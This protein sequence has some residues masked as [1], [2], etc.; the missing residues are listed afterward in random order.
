MSR[1]KS[2]YQ[3]STL[4]ALMAGYYYPVC[5]VGELLAHGDFGIGTFEG[6]DGE[7]IALDGVCYRAKSDGNVVP[8]S[9]EENVSFASIVSFQGEYQCDLNDGYALEDLKSLLDNK[10]SELGRNS[11]FVCRI[12][13]IFPKV[14]VR[15][16]VRQEKPYR[17]LLETM[18]TAKRDFYYNDEKG[19]IVAFYLPE[20]M[21]DINAAG[22]H[23]HIISEDRKRGG[24]VTDLEMHSGHLLLDKVSCISMKIPD[25][26]VF[27]NL[28]LLNRGE[29]VVAL[30]Q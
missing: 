4:Q 6:I 27:D 28:Q 26:A 8:S 22:W 15:S 25:D 3:F 16:A 9:A 18:K 5:S 19:T 2:I 24:H 23:F 17:E 13:G 29:E 11:F 30:E 1:P 7:L 12:D 20:Y 10:I 14:N 21:K